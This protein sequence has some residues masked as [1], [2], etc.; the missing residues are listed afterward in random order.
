MR[1]E[2]WEILLSTCSSSKYL[3]LRRPARPAKNE[4]SSAVPTKTVEHEKKKQHATTDMQESAK[5]TKNIQNTNNDTE[6]DVSK[7]CDDGFVSLAST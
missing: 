2:L 5:T 6:V 1:T 4:N 7:K 3:W